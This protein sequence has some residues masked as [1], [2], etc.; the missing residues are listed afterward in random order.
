VELNWTTFTLEVINFLILAWILAHFFYRPVMR[1]I[2]DRQAK[3]QAS[4]DS[5]EQHHKDAEALKAQYENRLA[6]WEQ[7]RATA[8]E[9]L[10]RDID[11][12]R[13]RQLE[14]LKHELAQAQEKARVVEERRLA[15]T[16]RRLEQTALTHGADF[17]ARLLHRV[18]SCELEIHLFDL[19]LE[20]LAALPADAIAALRDNSHAKGHPVKIESAF[21]IPTERRKVLVE[22]LTALFNG[23]LHCQFT[24]KPA[25]IAGLRITVGSWV[26]RANLND[27]LE[28]FAK[29]G[30]GTP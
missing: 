16:E 29:Y 27:E 13:T 22:R 6:A 21:A 11:A 2:A 9:A 17:A 15:Q 25:L 19:L 10:H 1:V 14:Q 28:A 3:I 26:L 4:L 20:D 23:E 30:H 5:A 8:R 18:A 24:E 12:E 7:E